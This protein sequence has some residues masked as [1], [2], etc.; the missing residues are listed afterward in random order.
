MTEIYTAVT[1]S[2]VEPLHNVFTL[3]SSNWHFS[4][5]CFMDYLYSERFLTDTF[6]QNGSVV[7]QVW[8]IIRSVATPD[9]PQSA[10]LVQGSEKVCSEG[11]A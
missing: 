8:E 5:R 4:N 10:L 7:R 3:H 11:P 6:L 2:T 1:I 9:M